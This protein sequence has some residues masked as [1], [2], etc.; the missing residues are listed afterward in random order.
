MTWLNIITSLS[1]TEKPGRAGVVA[2]LHQGLSDPGPAQHPESLTRTFLGQRWL[3]RLQRSQAQSSQ[4]EEDRTPLETP[5]EVEGTTVPLPTPNP[6]AKQQVPPSPCDLTA[7]TGVSVSYTAFS[8]STPSDVVDTH[9]P[10][11]PTGELGRLR[12]LPCT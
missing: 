1:P 4:E 3:F 8:L 11:I 6:P 7:A 12:H 9:V 2:L 10:S 5:S